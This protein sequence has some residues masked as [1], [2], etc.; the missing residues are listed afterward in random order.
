LKTITKFSFVFIAVLLAAGLVTAQQQINVEGLPSNGEGLTGWNAD[1]TGPEPAATGHMIPAAGFGNQFYYG[2]S[3]DYIS[4]NV[5]DA[6]CHFLPGMTGFPEFEQALTDNGFTPEQVKI[7]YGLTSLGD[8]IEGIDWFFMDD[9]AYS[10][11]YDAFIK[12]EL[13]GELMLTGGFANILMYINTQNG[14]W[15]IDCGYTPLKFAAEN[16]SPEVKAVAQAFLNDLDGKEM[17]LS[18]KS[19]TTGY[20][21]GNGRTGGYAS[22]YD[23]VLETGNPNLP[24]KGLSADHEGFAGWDADGTGPEPYGNGHITQ[25]YYVASL[26][27]DGID[28]D[29][30][31]CLGHFLEGATGF[32]NTMLQLQYRGFEIG[33]LKLKLGLNSLGPDVEGEDWGNGW[34]NYYNNTFTVELN[35]EP[36]LTIMVDTNKVEYPTN[37]WISGSPCAKVYNISENASAEAQFV[38]QSFLKDMGTHYLKSNTYEIQYVNFFNGNGRDG[39]KYEIIEGALVG[40]HEQATFV[41]EGVVEGT[42]SAENSPYYIDGHLTVEDGHTLTI[43]PGVRVA[44][45][46]PYHFNVQGCIKAQGTP[47]ENIVFTRSNPIFYWDGFDYDDTPATN[48][49]SLFDHCLF[50]YGLAQGASDKFNS[51]GIFTI[52]YFDDLKIRNSTFRHNV[53][54]IPGNYPPSGGAIAFEGSDLTIEKCIFYDNYAEY[55]G[56][57]FSYTDSHPVISNCLFYENEAEQGGAIAFYNHGYGTLINSTIVNNSAIYGGGLYFYWQSDPEIINTILW[58]NEATI[59]GNQV[60]SSMLASDPDFYYCDIE[61]GQAGFGGITISGA[62]LFNL[63]DDPDFMEEPP[64]AISGESPCFNAGTPDT[65]AWYYPEYLPQTCLCGNPRICYDRIDMGAYEYLNVGIEHAA[66]AEFDIKAQPNPF[67][68]STQIVF[69]LAEAANV[70]IEIYNAIGSKIVTLEN[71]FLLQGKHQTTLN[72]DLP[73]GIYF[74]R[75]QIDS[76]TTTLKIVKA[77]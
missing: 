23:G 3:L 1:G 8:D 71:G 49:A 34:C 5:N 50:E 33:S 59:S 72:H 58:G 77:R 60:Y 53:A 32:F 73:E 10:N 63:E 67:R 56:A 24:F 13:N 26:D 61:E 45:R 44:V 37:Y 43:E 27:Y 36:I 2:A 52:L 48:E 31:A 41:P 69:E 28:P 57:I 15:N 40:M 64:Y 9:F 29:P 62:Y 42:W 14:P 55:G 6:A 65:S 7:K 46:G 20:F 16:S 51:G 68:N 35:G 4:G 22:V 75:V 74:C 18:F 21:S 38:A 17:T 47:D 70:R 19:V 54:N 25:S 76:K 12:I 39:A 30:D 11:Y 66:A